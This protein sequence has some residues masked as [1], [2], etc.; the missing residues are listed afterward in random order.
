MP[1]T[2]PTYAQAKTDLANRLND[3]GKVH[4]LD[5]ELGTYIAEALR[6]WNS[7]TSHWREQGT[8]TLTMLQPFYDLP[9]VLP[10]LRAMT[11]TNW[12]LVADLQYSLMEPAAAGGT[13]TGTD[14]FTLQQLSD[15]IQ[16]RR[17]MFLQQTG[18]VLTRA[19]TN[20]PSPPAS[21]RIALDEAVLNV[22][23]AAWRVTATQLLLPLTRTDE[24]AG[25]HFAPAWPQSTDAPQN[26]SVSVVPPLT[27][28]IIAPPQG[29]GTLDLVSI[30]KG[31]TVNPS[32]S[33]ALGVPDDWAWVVK[34]GALA[35]LLQG[36]GLAL[37]PGRA[38]YCTQRWQQGIDMAKNAPVV[39]AGRINGVTVRINSL[40]DADSYSPV[41][42]LLA[43]V[44]RELLM[45]GQNLIG[46]IPMAGGG[47]PYTVALDV[48]QNAPIPV[49]AGDI[50][51]IGQD[52][53]DA[54]L[55]YA[56]HLALF[57]QG[58]GQVEQAIALLERAS[59]AAGVDVGIQQASQPSRAPLLTQQQ[60]DEHAQPRELPPVPV[61]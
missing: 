25:T 27:M 4:W 60:Q 6:W 20:Y 13:W 47:G 23:R 30:N 28:Q 40:S 48:V 12:D 43:G 56:N 35:D 57:K 17:D 32:V 21:G 8:F 9:T 59:A 31:A 36:D 38:N 39:L 10:T 15:A 3:Q 5:L 50:L 34:W 26:Y 46:S 1:Y 45:A 18:S 2:A 37:D 42:Q 52:V 53:Y 55:D 19:E 29:D 22:R 33:A 61:M 58:A 51:Q 44:P 11:L 49:N 24:W 16:R 14:Q 7:Q 41:W 54:L